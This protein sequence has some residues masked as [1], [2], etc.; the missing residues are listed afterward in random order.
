MGKEKSASIYQDL[1][2]LSFVQKIC[3][4]AM[5]EVIPGCGTESCLSGDRLCVLRSHLL[6]SGYFH[7]V[8]IHEY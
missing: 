1:R 3:S 5:R 4:N 2:N 7:Y 8:L 6:Q